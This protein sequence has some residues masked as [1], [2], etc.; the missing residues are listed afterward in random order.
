M[1]ET[2]LCVLL[3]GLR[4]GVVLS[5]GLSGWLLTAAFLVCEMSLWN[6]GGR[7][8][9]PERLEPWLAAENVVIVSM[10]VFLKAGSVSCGGRVGNRRVSNLETACH[11]NC[12]MHSQVFPPVPPRRD[13]SV[14]ACRALRRFSS[15]LALRGPTCR[16]RDLVTGSRRVIK[17]EAVASRVSPLQGPDAFLGQAKE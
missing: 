11:C 15:N 8:R 7:P 10:V 16:R 2:S 5:G 4:T 12:T 9:S 3:H 14:H 1:C 13:N 17:T 6:L